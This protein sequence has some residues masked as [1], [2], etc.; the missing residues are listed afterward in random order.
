[1][2]IEIMLCI[3]ICVVIFGGICANF[4][5]DDFYILSYFGA[6][7]FL[8]FILIGPIPRAEYPHRSTQ[9]KIDICLEYDS[10]E[11]CYDRFEKEY[12]DKG[13][14]IQDLANKGCKPSYRENNI[15]RS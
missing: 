5:S 10:C 12:N 11:G 6:I 1:M 4:I 15:L 7:L 14:L 2:F 9:D 3:S 13:N 8:V